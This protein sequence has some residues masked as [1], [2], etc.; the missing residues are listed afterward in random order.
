MRGVGRDHDDGGMS[1]TNHIT[2]AGTPQADAMYARVVTFRLA[3]L[4]A[5][6]YRAVAEGAA[7]AFAEWTGLIS[8]VWLADDDRNTYGG[9]YVFESPAA[10]AASRDTELF[11]AMTANPAFTDVTISEFSVLTGPTTVT[12]GPLGCRAGQLAG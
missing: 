4:S 5:D 6:E 12:G 8:K 9:I 10:A 1:S 11:Q 7:T 3:G 2:H